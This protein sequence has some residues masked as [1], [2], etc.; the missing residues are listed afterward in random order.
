[1]ERSRGGFWSRLDRVDVE[2][3]PEPSAEER[4]AIEAAVAGLLAG[5]GENQSSWWRAGLLDAVEEDEPEFS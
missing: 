3:H 4:A 1:V 2:I 5:Q